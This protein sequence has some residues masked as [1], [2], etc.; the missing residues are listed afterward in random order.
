MKKLLTILLTTS[1]LFVLAQNKSIPLE[2]KATRTTS[3][4]KIDADLNDDA[5]KSASKFTNFVEWRPSFGKIENDKNKTEIYLLYNDDAFYIGGYCHEPSVD[6]ISKEFIGRDQVGVND[7]VGVIFDTYNDK[8]NGFGYY[9]TPLGEQ[10]DAKYSSNGEDGSWNSVYETQSK[11]V[12]DGWIF[13]M[14]IP[15][16]AIRFVANPNQTWGVNITRKRVKSGKQLFWNPV[17]P[18]IGGSFLAQFGVL[19]EINNIKPP[20]RLSFSPYLS[21]NANHYPYNNPNQKNL[22]SNI[23]GGM[24]VK[25]GINQAFTLDMTLVPDFGQVQSDNQ[26]QNLGPFEI[27]FNENRSFFTEGTELFGKGNLF[28][29]RRIGGFP[30]NFGNSYNS[31][32]ANDSI[33]KNPIETKLINATK[34]SGRNTKGLGIGVLN[35]LTATQNAIVL[36][37]TKGETRE[38]ETS[39]LTNY[40]IFVLDQT[41]KNNS[42]ISLINTNVLR[43]GNTYD[44]NVTA[45]LWDFYDKK[46]NWNF[47]GKVAI[48]NLIGYE[49]AGKT[50][51]GLNY[52]VGF[53]KVGGRFNFNVW[54]ELCNDKYQ[55]ND[56]GYFTNNNFFDNG[57]WMAYKWLQPKRWYNRIQVNYNFWYSMRTTPLDYQNLGMNINVNA[58]LKNLWNVGFNIWYN[59]KS[60]DFYEPR[61]QGY[62]FKRPTN[63]GLGFWANTNEAKKYFTNFSF[64]AANRPSI[65]GF[66]FETNLFNQYRF[67]NNFTVSLSNYVD[68]TNNGKGF[69][70]YQGNEIILGLR[71]RIVAENILNVKYNFTN[72]MGLSFRARHYWS[73]T[74]HNEYFT[75]LKDGTEI[76]YITN[77]DIGHYNFNVFNIDMTYTWQFALGSFININWKDASSFQERQLGYFNNLNKT[78]SSPQNNSFSIK[79]IYFFDYLNLRKRS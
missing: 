37:K 52:A 65:Q 50:T 60:N 24:D 59:P 18:A 55:Q 21:F 34:I 51:T 22:T 49:N 32:G 23:N 71:N 64:Y 54:Q 36:D 19:K 29:S 9:V 6:S 75:L 20:V 35:A 74:Q 69:A 30:I 63:W 26:V 15:Y 46:N 3:Q 16:A 77:E 12:K 57:L 45:G 4:I 56:L 70:D 25:Y 13:E 62:V 8:I 7:F 61:V 42:S 43:S 47:N 41:L 67:N 72:K 79:I 78:L 76:P 17:N 28:Y 27:K 44:A 73:K 14:K 48:S 53:G 2:L 33:I 39:P 58:Q 66:G 31:L 5:W 11:I 10:F 68:V 40:N 1:C 38:V